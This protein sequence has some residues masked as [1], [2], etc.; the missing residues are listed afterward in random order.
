MTNERGLTL[1][2]I[3]VA[4]AIIG[5][6]LVGLFV[7][8]PISTYALQEGNQLSTATFLAEQ[9]LEEVRNA[10]WTASPANDCLGVSALSTAAP[11][12]TAC[13]RSF[14]TSCG[15]GAA[16]ATYAD[17]STV[18][19]FTGYGRT[20][21]VTSCSAGT[22]CG[23]IIDAGMRLVT[24]S[25]TYHPLSGVGGTSATA[26]KSATLDLLIAKH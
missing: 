19:G 4:V 13:S 22:G 20:V 14:P 10:P 25:V 2:E 21:R 1:V 23:G 3:L 12:S 6:G 9:K 16:C 18:P 26:Q 24:V 5:I 17:E 11:T 15:T 7:V 8:V